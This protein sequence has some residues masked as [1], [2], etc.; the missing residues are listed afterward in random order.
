LLYNKYWVDELYSITI[1]RPTL[2]LAEKVVLGFFDGVIIEGIVNG[3]P[4]LIDVFSQK[5]RKIQAGLLS[6]YALIMTIGAIF[7]VGLWIFM[8]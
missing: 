7:I 6:G 8:R 5:F 3:L 2:R 4:A 1:V